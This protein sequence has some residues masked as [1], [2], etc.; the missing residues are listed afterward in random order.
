MD[1]LLKRKAPQEPDMIDCEMEPQATSCEPLSTSSEFAPKVA[2]VDA[3]SKAK[4]RTY[5]DN[6]LKFGFISS[7][8]HYC[9]V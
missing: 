5:N 7:S 6:Y 1:G 4:K 3:N 9:P 8:V 2:K